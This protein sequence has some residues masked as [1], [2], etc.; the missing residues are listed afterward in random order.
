MTMR[1][2]N[3]LLAVSMLSLFL[4]CSVKVPQTF[5]QLPELPPAPATPRR[6]DAFIT[7]QGRMLLEDGRPFRFISVNVPNLHVVEDPSWR[8]LAQHPK[9]LT[10]DFWHRVTPFEQEDAIK[11]V[12]EMG[13]RVIRVYTLSI[14]GGRNNRKG[15]SHY[16]GPRMPLN[17]DLMCDYDSM[18]A[19][20]GKHGVRLILPFIDEWDWFGGRKEFAVLSG[21]GNFYT[22]P[23]VI[24]DFKALV[25]QVLTRV[26]TVTGVA[27]KDDPT[28]LAWETGNELQGVPKAW[29][30]EIA[31]WIKQLAPRQLVADGATHSV[32][33]IDDPNIDMVTD[34]F[35]ESSGR[36]FI[37]RTR[38]EGIRMGGTR[39]FYI[40]ECGSMDPDLLAGTMLPAIHEGLAGALIW[41]LR[42]HAEDGGFYWHAEGGAA[43]AYHWPGRG[44]SD[45]AKVLA[46]LREAAWAI[47][48]YQAPPR[49]KP[50]TPVLLSFSTPS[51]IAWR[52]SAGAERYVLQR[53]RDGSQWTE[54]AADL[55]DM[56]GPFK[57]YTDRTAPEGATLQYRLK[58][59]NE[60]GE[61]DWSNVVT[62]AP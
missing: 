6:N 25:E 4:G 20:C 27:Y 43:S 40:G 61:S 54:L 59:V 11:S 2:G 17:E 26:N 16:L 47:Q 51:A 37:A 5:L 44:R 15:P 56:D 21:G 29:T 58:A 39:P 1:S 8:Q 46:R 23:R 48:G 34:H 22:N 35:Y 50:G 14:Q 57:P 10:P 55:S 9:G 52:G 60:A 53:S 41:S 62:M 7:R 24:R 45:E 36:N 18:I 31:A 49:E 19:L 3:H 13:G 30:A 12:A 32:D 28:I 33:S 38:A 42:F